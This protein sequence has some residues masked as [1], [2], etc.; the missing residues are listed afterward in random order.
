MERDFEMTTATPYGF[1][2]NDEELCSIL[3]FDI[4]DN[5]DYVEIRCARADEDSY[6]LY[7]REYAKDSIDGN[8]RDPDF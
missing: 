4:T 2:H 7:K 8:P 1:I 3:I 5:G 6:A